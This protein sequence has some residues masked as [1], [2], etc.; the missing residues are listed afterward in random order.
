[1]FKDFKSGYEDTNV[2]GQ[3]LIVM[4]V[5]IAPTLLPMQGQKIKRMVQ[6][7]SVVLRNM[8]VPTAT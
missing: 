4:I 8:G 6:N 1:M 3:R 5:L 7:T 2:S